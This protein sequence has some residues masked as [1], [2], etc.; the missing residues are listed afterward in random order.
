M[1]IKHLVVFLLV[2]CGQEG[3]SSAP[4]LPITMVLNSS[5]LYSLNQINHTDSFFINDNLDV[6]CVEHNYVRLETCTDKRLT[7]S[8]Y[9]QKVKSDDPDDNGFIDESEFRNTNMQ[10][11]KIPVLRHCGSIL[12][13][14]FT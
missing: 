6:D 8:F 12:I 9:N 3:S 5:Q 4:P 13:Y 14:I 10:T 2:S 1:S 11:I 7:K